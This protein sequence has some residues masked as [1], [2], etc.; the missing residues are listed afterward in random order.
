MQKYNPVMY[1]LIFLF[2]FTSTAANSAT[3]PIKYTCPPATLILQ[4]CY[5]YD[6]MF[7]ERSKYSVQDCIDNP[8]QPPAGKSYV[9]A[10]RTFMLSNSLAIIRSDG[11]QGR[12]LLTAWKDTEITSN[13]DIKCTYSAVDMGGADKE[14]SLSTITSQFNNC[15][16]SPACKSSKNRKNCAV[17]C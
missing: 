14:V 5:L 15:K 4:A 10:F 8:V 16:I 11:V 17:E 7:Y 6:G 2:I 3:D 1:I 9:L 12:V 13:S